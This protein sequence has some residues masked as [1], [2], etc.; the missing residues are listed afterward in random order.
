MAKTIL[1]R[2]AA[3][4]TAVVALVL[5]PVLGLGAFVLSSRLT[6]ATPPLSIAGLAVAAL[7]AYGATRW[8]LRLWGAGKR[9]RRS[10]V[11]AV[12]ATALVGFGAALSLFRAVEGP[13]APAATASLWTLATGSTIAYTHY[14]AALPAREVALVF[15]HGGPAIP[16]RP[17]THAVLRRLA[18]EG[19]DVY[20]YD[21][22]GSGG[23]PHLASIREYS[24]DR[25]LRDLEEIR[26][27]IPNRSVVLAGVSWGAVL[28][29]HY[30]ARHP[31]EFAGAVFLSP[32]VLVDRRNVRYD[33]TKTASS[34]SDAVILPPARVIVAGLLARQNPDAAESFASQR[35]VNRAFDALVTGDSL[36]YQANCRGFRSTPGPT[37]SGGANFYANLMT[38]Q[39]LRAAAD[40]RAELVRFTGPVT[41]LR[42]EC[43]YIPRSVAESYA[44]AMPAAGIV[45]IPGAGHSLLGSAADRVLHE[46]RALLDVV[47]P[48]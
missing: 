42:G 41:L 17:G 10:A 43:D 1:L 12:V 37:R 6:A 14:P 24:L 20:L 39:S 26:G 32:G 31:A 3:V 5:V 46:T 21:Q 36:E 4:L 45:D 22:A 47:A 34:E 27:L 30:L 9:H 13:E 23:S 33:Y 25:H 8:V 35:E 18:D 38:S 15:L 48:R 44:A 7:A 28:G 2:L 29:A 16:P 19:V 11:A 40:P